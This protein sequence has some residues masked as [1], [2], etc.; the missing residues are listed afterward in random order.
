MTPVTSA[1]ENTSSDGLPRVPS[2]PLSDDSAVRAGD[3]ASIGALVR[4]ATTHLSTLIRAE[5]E[6]ARA[7]I[8]REVR[9]GVQGSVF[10]SI[11]LVV[12]LYSSFFLFFFL[13]EL[14]AEW[15]PRW[16]AFGIVFALMLLVA[17]LFALL[18]Y[19]RMKKIK[20]PERTITS[21][22]DT[23]AALRGRG[24]NGEAVTVTVD[25]GA[26]RRT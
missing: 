10:F 9:K 14:L 1:H 13:A 18:G 19:Q 7:E 24:E 25:S 11:A 20:A 23:A 26:A 21:M 4:D 22:K 16:A 8:G 17:G 15:L 12:L 6:L 5:M 3:D 2:I